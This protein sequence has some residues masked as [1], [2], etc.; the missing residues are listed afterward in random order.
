MPLKT[1][2]FF[3]L[4][5]PASLFS[6]NKI[7]A[8]ISA[9]LLQSFGKE[10]T[11]EYTSALNPSFIYDHLSKGKFRHPYL[12][13]MARLAY[14]VLPKL[15]LGLQSGIYVHYFEGYPSPERTTTLSVPLQL[16][17]R[18]I[19]FSF[20]NNSI[21]IDLSGGIILFDIKAGI[22]ERYKNGNLFKA[23]VFYSI[24]KESILRFGFEEQIDHVS[25]YL[26][27][28]DPS[29]KPETFKYNIK[30]TALFF[31]MVLL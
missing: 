4:I 16:T 30:R 6:Q 7:S 23:A 8:D 15:Q 21:G 17:S 12:N 11:E 31:L 20:P 26:Q 29:Y 3:L 10:K 27:A 9:S 13:I 28:A 5:T 19:Y 24:N 22:I 25:F 14:N 2:I 1:I 18:Y